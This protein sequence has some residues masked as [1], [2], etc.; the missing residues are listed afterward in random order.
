MNADIITDAS[1]P[2]G[3]PQGYGLGCH[4]SHCPSEIPC[5]DVHTRYNG[6]YSFR[7]QYD[8]GMTALDII[9]LE[10]EQAEQAARAR[11]GTRAKASTGDRRA[12]AN[13]S[14]ADN[15]ALIPRNTLRQLLDEGLTDAQIGQR[16]GLTRRQVTGTR[17]KTGWAHNP[18]RNR[19]T[20]TPAPAT[21][22]AS[23]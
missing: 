13:R 19:R 22:G 17:A 16:L 3:T 8:T 11:P 23:S 9:T 21:M 12:A 7:R 5:R 4:G 1:F 20:T 18:D 6:D 2:H 10:R 14:R 15:L